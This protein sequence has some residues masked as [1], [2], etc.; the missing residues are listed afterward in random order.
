MDLDEPPTVPVRRSIERREPL[1]RG[2]EHRLGGSTA[3]VAVPRSERPDERL[4]RRA[5][6]TPEVDGRRLL[7]DE[8]GPDV[9]H[10]LPHHLVL[11]DR[12][13]EH[14][15]ERLG[16][17]VTERPPTLGVDLVLG[18]TTTSPPTGQ[19]CDCPSTTSAP[20]F[21]QSTIIGSPRPRGQS[22][23]GP[24]PRTR[25]ARRPRG[26]LG[27]SQA[28]RAPRPRASVRSTGRLPRRR[29]G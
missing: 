29:R 7:L 6:R 14:V 26:T 2:G 21:G 25:T 3:D 19:S 10:R 20:Q 15:L 27:S 1:A 23:S 5:S 18:L 24:D 4:E 8:R 16:D 11:R 22:G 17:L 12:P 13:L 9:E 28:P